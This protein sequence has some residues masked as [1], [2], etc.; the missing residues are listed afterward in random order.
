MPKPDYDS[1][2]GYYWMKAVKEAAKT[3]GAV[4]AMPRKPRRTAAEKD[5]FG[6][7]DRRLSRQSF[8][9]GVTFDRDGKII[10]EKTA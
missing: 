8:I 10:R 9:I 7:V 2:R 5:F 1:G 4:E 6:Q 3:P